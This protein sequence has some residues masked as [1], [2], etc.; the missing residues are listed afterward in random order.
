MT[1]MDA[2]TL[3]VAR[4]IDKDQLEASIGWR[5]IVIGSL[6]NMVFKVGI[7][8]ILGQRALLKRVAALLGVAIIGGGL[9]LVF[10]PS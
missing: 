7:I 10:W 9:V 4:L 3:S 2:I 6:A 8:A 5:M 1:D